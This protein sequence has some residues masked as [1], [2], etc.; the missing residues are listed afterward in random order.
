MEYAAPLIIAGI[1]FY[2]LCKG[3][4]VFAAFSEGAKK[5][6][7]T[8]V[9]ILPTLLIMLTAIKM[10]QASGAV[11]AFSVALT[12]LAHLLGLP[13][14]CLPLALMRPFSGSGGL[15]LGSQVIK[16]YG[17][18]SF[19]GRVAAVMLGSAETSIYTIGV[20]SSY[21]KMKN[22]GHALPA[23]LLGDLAGFLASAFFVRLL[24]MR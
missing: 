21:V 5:G 1:V 6:L 24:M 23:A 20:Y 9:N 4:D 7:Q 11:D 8:A 13:P 19:A 14:E 22:T 12:P 15:A 2:G 3:V 17:A 16:L 18:D 10:L